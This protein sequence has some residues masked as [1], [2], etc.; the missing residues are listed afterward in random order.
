MVQANQKARQGIQGPKKK[1]PD[2]P[3]R[4]RNLC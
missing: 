1:Y 4:G 3:Q 2:I